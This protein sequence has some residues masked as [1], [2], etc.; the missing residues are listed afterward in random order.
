MFNNKKKEDKM[1]NNR[2]WLVIEKTTY[3]EDNF[4]YSITK[5]ANT[6]E[7]AVSYKVHLDALNDSKHKCYFIA[8]DISS[9]LG[10]V[11]KHHN[12]SVENGTYYEKHPEVKKPSEEEMPF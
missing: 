10:S 2:V 7:K 8:S 11:A 12:K 5:T 9:V 1:S 6:I 3:G 4:G